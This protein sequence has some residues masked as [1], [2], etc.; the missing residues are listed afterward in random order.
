MN[1]IETEKQGKNRRGA[2]SVKSA[3]Q[4]TV[5]DFLKREITQGN[6]RYGF[7]DQERRCWAFLSMAYECKLLPESQ[8]AD[9]TRKLSDKHTEYVEWK[10]KIGYTD[11]VKE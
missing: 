11:E 3:I 10:R 5:R 4:K 2:D 1:N 8:I 7:E 6:E 9:L